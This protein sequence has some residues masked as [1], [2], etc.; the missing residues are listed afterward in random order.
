MSLLWIACA[1]IA[2]VVA[3]VAIVLWRTPSHFPESAQRKNEALADWI[4]R[5]RGGLPNK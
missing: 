2:A 5:R 4:V 1:V 3:V